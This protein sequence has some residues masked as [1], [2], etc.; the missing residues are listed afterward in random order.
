M[1]IRL[2]TRW[3]HGIQGA[4]LT[5]GG[6]MLPDFQGGFSMNLFLHEATR[7]AERQREGERERE[8]ERFAETAF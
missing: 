4:P 1:V 5:P 6:V 2:K 3:D 7:T 8:R